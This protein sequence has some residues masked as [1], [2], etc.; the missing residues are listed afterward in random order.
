[1]HNIS[2]NS[3][4]G[5]ESFVLFQNSQ[6]ENGRGTLI[7]LTRNLVVFE[8]YNP[9]SIVQLS[10]VIKDLRIFRGE[11]AIYSGNAVVSN[12]VPTGLM[13]IISATLLDPW[14]DLA[15]LV[16]GQGLHEELRSF[17]RHWETTQ[18]LRPSY[19]LAVNKIRAFLGEMSRL[20][21]Q[22]DVAIEANGMNKSPT[23]SKEL[24]EEIRD[25]I[26]P[27]I[28]EVFNLIET[29]AIKI[30]PEE[31]SAHKAFL[32]QEIHQLFLCSPFIHRTYT[33]PLGYAGD[34]EMVNMMFR[35]SLQGPNTYAKVL[36][37]AILNQEPVNAHR[38]RI[39]ILSNQL[40]KEAIKAFKE[41]RPFRV[42]N[43]GCGP[44]LEVQEFLQ[45]GELLQ[46][47]E[48]HL[49]DFNEETLNH[50]R[51]KIQKVMGYT[52]EKPVI[53]FIRKSIQELLKEAVRYQTGSSKDSFEMVY[54]AGLFDYLSN[55]VCKRLLEL[56]HTWLTP[57]GL[58]LIT[59]V[60]PMNPIRYLMEHVAE[61]YLLY[62]D[63]NE[64]AD[65]VPNHLPYRIFKDPTG[66]NLFLEI[67][68]K[69][70]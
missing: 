15:G 12:L 59:N 33:K 30:P 3:V 49:L 23:I 29:E 63:E 42:M 54:C 32:R 51:E 39:E 26:V 2:N 38:N 36:N 48:F 13:L 67:R 5:I 45:Y 64:M 66:V 21:E 61:W 10:E 24:F 50:V 22:V 55:R 14:S 11:R 40:K 1:M 60:H 34:Y 6:G 62:R 35:D 69:F 46:Y 9:H 68:K 58:L 57:G 20:L 7:H 41:N 56:F 31:V 53:K 52:N 27:K 18:S 25:P 28:E 65:L 44:A 70:S 17:L 8:T 4:P 19:Q 37:F 47:C 16:P 43:V